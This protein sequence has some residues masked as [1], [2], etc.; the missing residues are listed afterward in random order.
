MLS[1]ELRRYKMRVG[2]QEGLLAARDRALVALR[3]ELARE[4]QR[5]QECGAVSP[6]QLL[7][8]Q[9]FRRELQ[10]RDDTIRQLQQ[11]AGILEKA[12]VAAERRL[13]NDLAQERRVQAELRHRLQLLQEEM[14]EKQKQSRF[15][16]LHINQLYRRLEPLEAAVAA[17]ASAAPPAAPPAPLPEPE[18]RVQLM[19][20]TVYAQPQPTA[21]EIAEATARLAAEEAAR[22]AAELRRVQEPAA[23]RIQA[24]YR[25]HRTRLGIAALHQKATVIQAGVRGWLARRE[26]APVWAAR[27][28]EAGAANASLTPAQQLALRR[29]AA[30]QQYRE[31][32]AGRGRPG[33]RSSAAA[34]CGANTAVEALA[35]HRGLGSASSQ[36]EGS[37]GSRAGSRA[38][39]T[40]GPQKGSI[41]SGSPPAGRTVHGSI[42]SGSPGAGS[43]AGI[44]GP[45]SGVRAAATCG[46]RAA[47]IAAVPPLDLL[48][49]SHQ[50]HQQGGSRGSLLRPG[51]GADSS[52]STQGSL[53]GQQ[54][55]AAGDGQPAPARKRPSVSLGFAS[56]SV[57]RSIAGAHD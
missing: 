33:R 57:R 31:R 34:A 1:E 32:Q 20:C 12:K 42:S 55:A 48:Q 51:G 37:K 24:A 43:R 36:S 23:V 35:R 25:G 9:Q 6:G 5:R 8:D 14:A 18:E 47:S 56:S 38:G 11:K 13:G 26:V 4:R 22:A 54:P 16:Q 7:Q 3:D 27:L 29:Q 17:A 40:A 53:V 44:A 46:N 45:G 30:E 50:Q 15:N 52:R 41:S 2:E 10:A 39:S 19:L 21:A 49:Q 28:A